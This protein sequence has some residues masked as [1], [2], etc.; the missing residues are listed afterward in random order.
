MPG[1][2]EGTPLAMK[3]YP[4]DDRTKGHRDDEVHDLKVSKYTK[5]SILKIFKGRGGQ[6]VPNHD[7]IRKI[8][9]VL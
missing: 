6:G 8:F 2:R 3:V 7:P 4:A 1:D 9:S 5:I